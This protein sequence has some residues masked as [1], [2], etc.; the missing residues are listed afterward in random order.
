MKQKE[1][2]KIIEIPLHTIYSIY[3]RIR[4]IIKSRDLDETDDKL[5]EQKHKK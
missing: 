4:K 2:R 5:S 1:P 3:K